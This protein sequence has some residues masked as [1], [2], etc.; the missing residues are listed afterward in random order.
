MNL[1]S[2]L[3]DQIKGRTC[4]WI[5]EEKSGMGGLRKWGQVEREVGRGWW[6][7]RRKQDGTKPCGQEKLQVGKG[8]IAGE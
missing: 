7:R 1:F 3:T 6:K 2:I 5:V 8:F 4:D